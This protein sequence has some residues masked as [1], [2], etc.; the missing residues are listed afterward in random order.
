MR[1]VLL[2]AVSMSLAAAVARAEIVRCFVE[3]S[4]TI[5]EVPVPSWRG[6]TFTFDLQTGRYAGFFL[7]TSPYDLTRFLDVTQRKFDFTLVRQGALSRTYLSDGEKIGGVSILIINTYRHRFVLWI[8]LAIPTPGG[9]TF[10]GKC[11]AP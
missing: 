1:T 3:R 9:V 6:E 7:E 2:V 11:D 5:V 4:S 8:G 10:Y